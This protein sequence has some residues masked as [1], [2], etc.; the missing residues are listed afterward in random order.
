MF[1]QGKNNTICPVDNISDDTPWPLLA[2]QPRAL[3]LKWQ[4]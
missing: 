2:S 4:F 3:S 1:Y